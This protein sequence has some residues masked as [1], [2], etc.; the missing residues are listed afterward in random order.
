[1]L[2]YRGKKKKKKPSKEVV[3]EEGRSRAERVQ[4]DYQR[5]RRENHRYTTGVRRQA[6]L[7]AAALPP[8]PNEIDSKGGQAAF[9]RSRTE[10]ERR[11][12]R[13]EVE[14]R[15]RLK[16]SGGDSGGGEEQPQVDSPTG[17]E[18][19]LRH[20]LERP[21]G[22]V[23]SMM[24]GE[25][26]GMSRRRGGGGDVVSMAPNGSDRFGITSMYNGEDGGGENEEDESEEEDESSATATEA[27]AARAASSPPVGDDYSDDDFD[28]DDFEDEE[29]EEEVAVAEEEEEVVVVAEIATKKEKKEKKEDP[30]TTPPTSP[31]FP[32]KLVSIEDL[33]LHLTSSQRRSA[34]LLHSVLFSTEKGENEAAPALSS[35]RQEQVRELNISVGN[36]TSDHISIVTAVKKTLANADFSSEATSAILQRINISLDACLRTVAGELARELD[37]SEDDSDSRQVSDRFQFLDDWTIGRHN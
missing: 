23:A 13:E 21:D 4:L 22:V 37:Q 24:G 34:H 32:P 8:M 2:K 35:R 12:Q 26:L 20:N 30:Q 29:D 33:S 18:P 31:T 25:E 14:E 19:G 11:R 17:S 9:R 3:E 28:D 15:E 16:R 6:Y 1:V 27:T 5:K 10:E 36:F 7:D